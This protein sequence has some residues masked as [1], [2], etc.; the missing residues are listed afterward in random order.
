[1]NSQESNNISA[2]KLYKIAVESKWTNIPFSDW[3]E[4]KG[5]NH[6]DYQNK[7]GVL[8]FYEWEV[9]N[10]K[11]ELRKP[12]IKRNILIL[13]LLASVGAILIISKNINIVKNN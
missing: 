11:K 3:I 4:Q 6:V 7:G 9:E 1:M 8:N 5:K 13:F 2:N 12:I 10:Q